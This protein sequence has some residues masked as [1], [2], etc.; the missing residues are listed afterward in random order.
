MRK[1]LA[2]RIL[3]V[4]ITLYSCENGRINDLENS[5]SEL[6]ELNS[7]L[8]DSIQILKEKI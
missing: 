8:I 7:K 2:S 5:V 1:I 3:A 4:S 6:T